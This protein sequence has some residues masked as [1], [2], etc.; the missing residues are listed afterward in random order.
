MS[1]DVIEDVL[2]HRFRIERPPTLVA[3]KGTKAQI[4]FSRMSSAHAMRGRSLA[5]PLENSFSIHVPLSPDFFSRLW[6]GGNLRTLSLPSPGDAFLFDLSD[7]PVVE[8][9]TPFDS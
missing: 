9:D 2:A 4:A 5:V 3:H 1:A 8:L 7:N 6:I